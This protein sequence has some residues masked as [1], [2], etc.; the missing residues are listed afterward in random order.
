MPSWRTLPPAASSWRPRCRRRQAAAVAASA[1]PA[2]A[3]PAAGM[4]RPSQRWLI[5][6][7]SLKRCASVHLLPRHPGC[8]APGWHTCIM[9]ACAP[10]TSQ[11]AAQLRFP[12]PCLSSPPPANAQ[13]VADATYF[14][15]AYDL[16]QATLALAALREQ[17]EAAA[18]ELQPR[19]RFAFNR[20][21]SAKASSLA[22]AAAAGDAPG[23]T[24]ASEPAAGTV[25]QGAAAAAGVPEHQPQQAADQQAAPQGPTVPA[26]PAASGNGDGS[27]LSGLRGETIAPSRAEAEGREFTLSDLEDCTVFLPAPLAALFLHGLRRCRVYTG[28]VAGACFVEGAWG[29]ERGCSSGLSG[30]GRG[31]ACCCAAAAGM[32]PLEC[33]RAAPTGGVCVTSKTHCRAS[34]QE[35]KTAC[36]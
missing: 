3:R 27:T 9:R 28:P 35:R 8:N 17:Q 16:R 21:A 12:L 29:G 31:A 32:W 5:R 30:T 11:P 36:S 18:A 22:A 15:P 24:G 33:G 25:Q 23:G 10:R 6:L 26:A 1:R 7:A 2:A 4:P 19:R 14:L 13:A 20:K 34:A